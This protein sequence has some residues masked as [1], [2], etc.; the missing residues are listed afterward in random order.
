MAKAK[1]KGKAKATLRA[2]SGGAVFVEPHEP[3]VGVVEAQQALAA[4]A[5]DAMLAEPHPGEAQQALVAEHLVP[6]LQT[7]DLL[8]E[9]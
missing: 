5:V 3:A 2:D 6:G 9:A 4:E 7:L 8:R 1:G